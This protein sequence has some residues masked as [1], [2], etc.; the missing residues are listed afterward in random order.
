GIVLADMLHYLQPEEQKPVIEKCMDSLHENGVLIIRDGNKEMTGRHKK[1]E[2]TEFYSTKFFGFNKTTEK[3][4]SFLSASFLR[5][6][7][8]SKKMACEEINPTDGTSNMIFIIKRNSNLS[9]AAV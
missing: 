3:G 5:E 4:L 8:N 1:T 6:L 7:V 2:Q 9:H